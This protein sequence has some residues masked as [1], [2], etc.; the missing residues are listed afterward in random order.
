MGFAWNSSVFHCPEPSDGRQR[1]VF[2]LPLLNGM[3]TGSGKV[4][5]SVRQRIAKRREKTHRVNLAI[6]ALNSMFFGGPHKFQKWYV[7]DLTVLPEIQRDAIHNIMSRV[8]ELGPPL[9]ASRSEALKVL[10]TKEPSGYSEPDA[11]S[12]STVPMKL[13]SLSLPSSAVGGV[14]LVGALSGSVRDM[15]VDF[16]NY[17]LEDA[18]KWNGLADTAAQMEPYNDPLLNSRKGYLSFLSRLYES[19]V[20]NFRS[21]CRGRVGAFCVAKKPKVV[22]GKT[23]HRQ[24]LVLDCRQTN[25]IF[26]PPPQTRLGSLSALA[27]AELPPDES[28]YVAGADIRDCFYAVHM[29][30]GLQEFFGL[31]WNISDD[32]VKIVSGGKFEGLGGVNVPVIKVLPMGFSWSFYLVQ[33]MHTQVALASL[34]KDE[35]SLFLDGQ[36][37]PPLGEHQVCIMPYCDNL[38]SLSTSKTS[39]QSAEDTMASALEEI[40][41]DLHEHAEASTWFPTLGGVIDGDKGQV[42][43][44][45]KRVWQ[46]I[47]AFEMAAATVVSPKTIQ[48]L[49]GHSM[50]ICVLNRS[51]MSV[52][53]KLYDFA[54]S[55]AEPRRLHPSESDE[56]WNFVGL[57]PLL[58]A[59]IRREW[60]EFITCT[61]ASPFGFGICEQHSNSTVV[62]RHA[63]WNERWRFRRLPASQ[64]K[65][66]ERSEGWDTLNDV[67]TVV[68]G[69]ELDDDLDNYVADDD[70]PE[71]PDDLL[72]PSKWY[73][74]KMG[75]WKYT[76]EH[77][78]LKEAKALLIAIRRLSRSKLNRNK[79]HLILLDNLALVFAVGKGRAHS[80][81]LLR[82]LQRIAAVCLSCNITIRPR[83]VRS[84]VN[85]ADAPSR[86]F[87]QP[88]SAP[89][90]D[91]AEENFAKGG[92]NCSDKG[93]TSV[94]AGRY[95]IPECSKP[96]S[97]A[98][99][100]QKDKQGSSVGGRLGPNKQGAKHEVSP[101][102]AAGGSGQPSPEWLDDPSR[103]KV[104]EQRN[105]VS[106]QKLLP[107]V[108]GLLEGERPALAF[109]CKRSRLGAG[110]LHGHLVSGQ[111]SP[112]RR[113]E[114]S[115]SSGVFSTRGQR[116][117]TKKQK[118]F[119]RVAQNHAG[120][121]PFAAPQSHDVRCEHDPALQGKTRHGP[122]DYGGLRPLPETRRGLV[123]AS[124]KYH[125]TSGS[126]RKPVQDSDSGDPRLRSWCARQSRNLRHLV[127][128]G[129]PK[130][131]MAES[132][133]PPQGQTGQFTGRT[134]VHI[135]D[136]RV[137][138]GIHG[139]RFGP[140][141]GGSTSLSAQTWWSFRGPKQSCKRLPGSEEPGPMGHRPE[142]ATLRQDRADPTA[143]H[144]AQGPS[145]QLLRMVREEHGE[146]NAR[147]DPSSHSVR[148]PD[149]FSRHLRP[150]RFCLEIFAGCARITT[151]LQKR[152]FNA[153]TVDTCI[154]PSHNVL[155]HEVE[156]SI[157]HFIKSGRVELIWLGMP[158]TT[159]SRAR[160]YD[161]IGP[162]PLRTPE[163]I[164]GLP[165]LSASDQ[166]KLR[167]GNQLFLF[168]LRILDLCFQYK[169]PF[170]VENPLSSMAWEVPAFQRF[171]RRTGSQI[172][173]L[174]FCMYGQNWKKPTRLVYNFL[175][176]S[177]LSKRCKS[178]SHVC[179][180]TSRPHIPLKGLADNGKFMTLVAQPY[181]ELLA[182]AFASLL[183][184]SLRG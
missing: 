91:L 114:D 106:V 136:G 180:R 61:D 88:G 174:D 39:C 134:S 22:D 57:A 102:F 138:K 133:P 75:K 100:K 123:F 35:K 89:S 15:V 25:L 179:S 164:W 135:H 36:P 10:R 66:R 50:V 97:T 116:P 139:R 14:D 156:Q 58:I 29:E 104:S 71:I 148:F 93:R 84:E 49:L 110:R 46:V 118:G 169:V 63:R 184:T 77:I 82:V 19:G 142:C 17:L 173:D 70:F 31:K 23:I 34:G 167:Q 80:F 4:C 170:V 95:K 87:I 141:C 161:G 65:P 94:E 103:V 62:R 42:R 16:E 182:E 8:A 176:L 96:F 72:L 163:H 166:R 32:E 30:P 115:G 67:R 122:D 81:E 20:L 40:G 24:R 2:P 177:P 52:F 137:P 146:G 129:Q 56:C 108:R 117:P 168:T 27:E 3:D 60:S 171:M 21:S 140:G 105:P 92:E 131:S 6:H 33:H 151:A 181:P 64:W 41:F 152:G 99:S 69:T 125:R 113:R 53:R 154:F 83:W 98:F 51:G 79:R 18:G 157:Q 59:D 5:R 121:K 119:E 12:G 44:T 150:R 26:K 128:D 76:T 111:E 38:H 11:D 124:S 55:N 85:V 149:I 13:N 68:G 183:A 73:T 155:C 9:C 158:C 126:C 28:L 7:N 43:P 78:T 86:G 37:S 145:A 48:R 160:R 165:S 178:A 74:V 120:K 90:K 143:A 47:Y 45:S 130:D 172:C 107:Q 153:Y 101:S 162:G 147:S 112:S 144:Q 159:F 132:V 175:D 1:D 54:A 127:E 109:T